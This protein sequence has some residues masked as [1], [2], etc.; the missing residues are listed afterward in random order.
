MAYDKIAIY[1]THKL[2]SFSDIFSTALFVTPLKKSIQILNDTD[3]LEW[4]IISKNWE[5]FKT[6]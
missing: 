4:M 2:S 6:K 3:W 5:I 1:L